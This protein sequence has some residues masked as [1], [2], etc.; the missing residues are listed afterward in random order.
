MSE[1]SSEDEEEIIILSDPDTETENDI[2]DDDNS[3]FTYDTDLEYDIYLDRELYYND[4]EELDDGYYIGVCNNELVLANYVTA[5]MF[6]KYPI[7]RIKNY[8]VNWSIDANI[9]NGNIEIVRMKKKLA[10][11]MIC[12]NQLFTI[13]NCILKTHYLKIVQNAW[14]RVL[15]YRKRLI[16]CRM[17]I[18]SIHYREIHGRWPEGL[19]FWPKLK[20]CIHYPNVFDLDMLYKY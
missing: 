19:S 6:Y 5:K 15:E 20:G 13:Y 10:Y 12:E 3:S 11:S 18:N 17:N 8:L 14:R 4:D 1:Y 7:E 9:L 16:Q 2:L